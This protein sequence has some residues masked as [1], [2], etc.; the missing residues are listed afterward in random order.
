VVDDFSMLADVGKMN[1]GKGS[2]KDDSFQRAEFRAKE[3]IN[4]TPATSMRAHSTM[5]IRPIVK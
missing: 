5:P 4:L 1:R 2:N 3:H